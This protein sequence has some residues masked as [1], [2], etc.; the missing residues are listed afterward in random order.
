MCVIY[1]YS[2]IYNIY[3]YILQC[4]GSLTRWCIFDLISSQRD[5]SVHPVL[6]VR[7]ETCYSTE[8]VSS[9]AF[10]KRLVFKI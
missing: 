8:R 5:V 10:S 1:T 2:N 3:T 6:L 7:E 4:I 9:R